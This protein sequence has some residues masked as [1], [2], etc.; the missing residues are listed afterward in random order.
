MLKKIILSGIILLAYSSTKA[1][2]LDALALSYAKSSFDELYWFFSL[3]ND[4]N[5]PDQI[6]PNVQWC[7]KVFSK[8]GF[9]TKR[10]ETETVA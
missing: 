3:P 7:E 10:L 9:Q 5:H 4:A 8:R 2:D 6:E 1:Q